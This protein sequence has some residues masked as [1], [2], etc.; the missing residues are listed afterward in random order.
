MET[1]PTKRKAVAPFGTPDLPGRLAT[2]GRNPGTR[3][4]PDSG[5]DAEEKASASESRH[6][7]ARCGL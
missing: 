7:G 5:T 4:L 6:G 2:E 3:G 1:F